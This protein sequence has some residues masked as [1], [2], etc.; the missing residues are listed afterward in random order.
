MRTIAAA[1]VRM[2]PGARLL[3]VANT[4]RPELD[5]T[6]RTVVEM[7]TKKWRY[8]LDDSTE[9]WGD[10]PAGITIVDADTITVPLGGPGHHDTLRFVDVARKALAI[11][12]DP[13]S[14]ATFFAVRSMG[15]DGAEGRGRH[16]PAPHAR[17]R[18]GPMSRQR[19]HKMPAGGAVQL[20]LGGASEAQQLLAEARRRAHQREQRRVPVDY[21]ALNRMVRRQRAALTRAVR[22][23]DTD[24]VVL[25]CRDAVREWD[26]PGAMWPDDWA[27]W[28]RALDDVL[29]WRSPVDLRDL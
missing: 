4:V 5:G 1:K 25:A 15:D 21:A 18:A 27:V 20:A 26:Q 14:L 17:K 9:G 23:G 11:Q 13:S 22:S 7:G 28:Q 3:C 8:R 16:R 6:T 12:R 2:V 29:P 24:R 19:S 10:W